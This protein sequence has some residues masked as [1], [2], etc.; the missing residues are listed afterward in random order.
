MFSVPTTGSGFDLWLLPFTGD[1]KPVNLLTSP[2]DEMHGSFAP[3]APLFA[4]AS[5]EA[6]RFEVYVQTIPLSEKK[7][8]ISGNGGYEP[9][10]RADG[11]ELYYL[12]EDRTLM[13]VAVHAGPSF[14][15]PRPLFQTRVPEGISALRSNYVAA[16]DG[17]SF[18]INMQTSDRLTP[19]TVVLNWQQALKN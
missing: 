18:L 12:A 15:V 3:N 5:N 16:R 7:W 14:G 19:I 9:R 2:S 8:A 1:R 13:A 17:N 4:Y 10:W 11:R 6:G